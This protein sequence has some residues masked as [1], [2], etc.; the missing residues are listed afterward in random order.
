[1]SFSRFTCPETTVL[2]S[3]SFPAVLFFFLLTQGKKE[4]SASKKPSFLCRSAK[5]KRAAWKEPVKRTA[6][7]E[8]VNRLIIKRYDGIMQIIINLKN[9]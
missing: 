2:F 5:E 3:S 1:M 6:I 8:H 9:T 7:L 4:F